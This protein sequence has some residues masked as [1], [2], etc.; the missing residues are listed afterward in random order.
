MS[1]EEKGIVI[2]SEGGGLSGLYRGPF[3]LWVW[4]ITNL[5]LTILDRLRGR[6]GA[7]TSGK[8]TKITNIRPTAEGGWSI[9]EHE[10]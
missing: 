4:P 2:R 6:S 7:V 9:L 8:R 3:G 1:E 10:V 5:I